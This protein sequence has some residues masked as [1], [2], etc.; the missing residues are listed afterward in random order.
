MTASDESRTVARVF[1]DVCMKYVASASPPHATLLSQ[2][3]VL[4]FGHGRQQFYDFLRRL[5][6]LSLAMHS[7]PSA[8]NPSSPAAAL[9]TLAHALD[10]FEA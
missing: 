2:L 7:Q 1:F 5:R 10:G 4:F 3:G 8:E 6:M 9:T